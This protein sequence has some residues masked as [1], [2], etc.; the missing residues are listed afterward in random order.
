[1]KKFIIALIMMIPLMV[2]AQTSLMGVSFGIPVKDFTTQIKTK[3]QDLASI[4][5]AKKCSVAVNKNLPGEIMTTCV[6]EVEL[7]YKGSEVNKGFL[8]IRAALTSRYGQPVVTERE[9]MSKEGVVTHHI[10]DFI[11]HPSYGEV[12]VNQDGETVNITILDYHSLQ[13]AYPDLFKAF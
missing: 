1:M 13:G 7:D 10:Q 12:I 6:A 3:T 8:V 4:A 11:W 2:S 9:V 5:R